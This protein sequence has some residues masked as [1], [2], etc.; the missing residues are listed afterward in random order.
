MLNEVIV[1]NDF[2]ISII[3]FWHYYVGFFCQVH[4]TIIYIKENLPHLTEHITG[5]CTTLAAIDYNKL[6]NV[7]RIVH[8]Q[9]TFE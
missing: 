9:V 4:L 7:A 6:N 2:N 1:K 3:Y 8:E 5:G